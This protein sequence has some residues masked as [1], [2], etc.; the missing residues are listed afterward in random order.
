MKGNKDFYIKHFNDYHQIQDDEYKSIE[1]GCFPPK[2]G[3]YG[4][5]RY[6]GLFYKGR[7]PSF[8]TVFSLMKERVYLGSFYHYRGNNEDIGINENDLKTQLQKSLIG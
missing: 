8:K 3:D 2:N 4:Y 6:F 7:K 5:F 1:L